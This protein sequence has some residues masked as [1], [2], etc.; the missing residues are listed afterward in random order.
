MQ[1]FIETSKIS[2]ALMDA[3]RSAE[4]LARRNPTA[5]AVIYQRMEP[6]NTDGPG[7]EL[8]GP[9]LFV[10][11]STDAAPEG[12]EVVTTVSRKPPANPKIRSWELE[13]AVEHMVKNL[14]MG[15]ELLDKVLLEH[16]PRRPG[17]DLEVF[18]VQFMSKEGLNV[19]TWI[20]AI[21]VAGVDFQCGHEGRGRVYAGAWVIEGKLQGP[22]RNIGSMIESVK[23]QALKPESK[24]DE[25]AV[26]AARRP[27]P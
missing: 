15:V 25:I 2:L 4:D 19:G 16:F 12:A 26:S 3:M 7:I 10:R 17:E 27:R 22:S 8:S 24:P 6:A 23:A 20:P 13:D 5:H 11:L 21:S 1:K 18:A 14:P 9:R